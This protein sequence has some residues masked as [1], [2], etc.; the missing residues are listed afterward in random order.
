M[1]AT[2]STTERIDACKVALNDNFIRNTYQPVLNAAGSASELEAKIQALRDIYSE[3]WSIDTR[4]QAASILEAL[5]IATTSAKLLAASQKQFLT[6]AMD[7]LLTVLAARRGPQADRDW[8]RAQQTSLILGNTP[9]E[10]EFVLDLA[11][12]NASMDQRRAEYYEYALPLAQQ[13]GDLTRIDREWKKVQGSLWADPF[14]QR[15]TKK[16]S[17]AKTEI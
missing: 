17:C 7:R 10:I 5:G 1:N 9:E 4:T 13:S 11:Q 3:A 2:L 6:V 8:T 12:A 14:L 16:A 15:W